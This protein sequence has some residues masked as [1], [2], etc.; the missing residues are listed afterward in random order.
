VPLLNVFIGLLKSAVFG[1]LIALIACHFGFRI[2]PN[3]ESLGNETTNSVVAS[4]TIVIMVDAVFAFCSWHR[5]ADMNNDAIRIEHVWTRFGE[6]VV[7]ADINLTLAQGEIL[8][9]VGASGC[10]KTTL[11]REIIGL[12]DPSEAKS[13]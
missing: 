8:G 12:T 7:H 9:L 10:G 4:I 2:K 11:L 1:L 3:T 13:L 5:H 6:K